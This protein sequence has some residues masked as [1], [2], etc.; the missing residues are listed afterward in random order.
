MTLIKLVLLRVDSNANSG[1]SPRQANEVL[2]LAFL[3]GPLCCKSLAERTTAVDGL[4]L[5]RA[6]SKNQWPAVGPNRLLTVLC[7]CIQ[8]RPSASWQ[9]LLVADSE[10]ISTMA[11]SNGRRRRRRSSL[12]SAICPPN[13]IWLGTDLIRRC[14]RRCS[15]MFSSTGGQ[16]SLAIGVRAMR[17][18]QAVAFQI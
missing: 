11:Q 14:C 13:G 5:P 6:V 18:R 4:G 2:P 17:L 9:C 1:R 16:L 8:R 10:T 15:C 12:R 3:S 7:F